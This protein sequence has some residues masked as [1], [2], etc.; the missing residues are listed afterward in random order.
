M[1]AVAQ[2]LRAFYEA[3]EKISSSIS[4]KQ[5]VDLLLRNGVELPGGGAEIILA[6]LSELKG[7]SEGFS[8]VLR[9]EE[10]VD[11]LEIEL[12]GEALKLSSS[13]LD[14]LDS[15]E[16]NALL[17]RYNVLKEMIGDGTV[18]ISESNGTEESLDHW[19]ALYGFLLK[20]GRKG[21]D[22]Q[23]YKGL[24]EMN[25]DQLWETTLDSNARALL[26]VKVAHAD[27]A[28][29][30]FSTLMGDSVEARRKFIQSRALEVA[31]LDT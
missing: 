2:K 1:L 21:A 8:L 20:Y 11:N 28:A 7:K 18:V 12:G 24:G 31:N 6:R 10:Q 17:E 22:I 29:G 16:Y 30:I 4:L 25:P 23:R 3:S 13:T 14:T 15:D 27:E 9:A 5:L 19:S 26:Q